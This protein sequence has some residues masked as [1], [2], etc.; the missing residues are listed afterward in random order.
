MS[1]NTDVS[2]LEDEDVEVTEP[3]MFHVI[4]LNDDKTTMD[5]VIYVLVEI[6][7]KSLRDA[8]EI[9]WKVHSNGRGIAGT[10]VKD[11]AHTKRNY[12]ISL[13]R[14]NGFP[15]QLLIERA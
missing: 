10:Y 9:M 6:F 11:I 14:E 3:G 1:E 4:L 5:F 2:I 7:D 15:L 13:A 8:E 12:T